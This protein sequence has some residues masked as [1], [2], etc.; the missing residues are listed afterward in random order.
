MPTYDYRC[1]DCENTFERFTKVAE[2]N[3][4]QTCPKCS[5][6]NS[7]KFIGGAPGL[8]DSF[9]LGRIKPD[10]DFRARMA[11]IHKNTPGSILNK[12]SRWV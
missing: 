9:S 5:G 11:E 3:D 12:T 4:P 10:S 2:M 8:T 1:K 7:E 6:T